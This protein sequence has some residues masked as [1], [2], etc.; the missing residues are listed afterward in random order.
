MKGI[1]EGK[2]DEVIQLSLV[3]ARFCEQLAR[4]MNLDRNVQELFLLGLFS[5]LDV[6][7]NRPMEEVLQTLYLPEAVRQALISKEGPYAEIFQ[8]MLS[9]EKAD[10]SLVTQIMDK[11]HMEGKRISEAYLEALRWVDSLNRETA[12]V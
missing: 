7:M 5:C 12:A 3:R 1:N 10:W 2:P 9:Y 6:L 4:S 11:W 8:L